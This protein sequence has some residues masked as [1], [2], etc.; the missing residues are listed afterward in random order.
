M[1]PVN[2]LAGGAHFPTGSSED[3]QEKAMRTSRRSF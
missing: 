1:N 3:Y 2:F